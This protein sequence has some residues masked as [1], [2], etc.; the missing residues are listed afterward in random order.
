VIRDE[1]APDEIPDTLIIGAGPAGLAA[2]RALQA[3][4]QRFLIVDRAS[5]VGSAWR[6]HY[7]RLHLHTV[8]E[9][10]H[11][12]DLPMPADWPRYVAR[13]Q[14]V[15]YLERYARHFGIEPRFNCEVTRIEPHAGRWRVAI[16]GGNTIDARHVILATGTNRIPVE[17]DWPGRDTTSMPI[18]HS[19]SY[20]SPAAFRGSRVLVVGMGNTGA[21]IALDLAE[22]GVTTTLSVRGP[23]NVI[24]RDVLGLPVQLTALRLQ[25]LPSRIAAPIGRLLQRLTV[26]RLEDVGL[27]RPD[28]SPLMQLRT[29]GKTPVI[30]VG[31][32]AAI[33]RG[34][35]TVR[36]GIRAFGP[37]EVEFA[38]GSAG[39]FD[40]VILATGYR[41]D[42]P[43]LVPA[44]TSLLDDR[45]YPQAL[46]GTGR[47]EG[48]YFLG[49]N[50]YDAGGVLRTIRLDAVR[51]AEHLAAPDSGR[52]AQ[53]ASR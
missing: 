6:Q 46:W 37:H 14:V 36:P 38:D 16:P 8:K 49:F 39:T 30:D 53:P 44:A 47:L 29:T 17:P 7:E 48:L 18:T 40:H 23:V 43:A 5:D 12:P 27:R 1:L 26:G 31:T 50:P 4:H 33:R 42:L 32:L 19:R 51:I 41:P 2:A 3:R 10:S 34:A 24:R 28:V 9:Q 52:T 25:R 15:E 35:I 20:R 22:H 21:E 45:G 13:A 11:L